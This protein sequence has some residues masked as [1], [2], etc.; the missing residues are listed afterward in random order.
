MNAGDSL[1]HVA[2]I[3]VPI[4]VLLSH[5]LLV[6]DPMRRLRINAFASMQIRLVLLVVPLGVREG[7]CSSR[8]GA[9]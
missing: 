1:R 3:L 4:A 9:E 5:Q 7:A 8:G 6:L 2:D